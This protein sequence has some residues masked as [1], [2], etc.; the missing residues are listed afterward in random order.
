MF[1]STV[2][3]Y[4]ILIVCTKKCRLYTVYT[5]DHAMAVLTRPILV[6]T[7]HVYGLLALPDGVLRH[8]LVRVEVVP[9]HGAHAQ[10]DLATEVVHLLLDH[11]HVRG[12]QDHIAWSMHKSQDI[13][14]GIKVPIP[15]SH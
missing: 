3:F 5:V 6:R 1:M 11:L 9:P 14:R 2:P 4:R 15:P 7:E 13:L 12:G 10:L 8:A